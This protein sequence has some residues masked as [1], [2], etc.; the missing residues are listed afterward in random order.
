MA[1][2]AG[3]MLLGTSV[4]CLALTGCA[5][6]RFEFRGYS[7]LSSCPEIIDAELANGATFQ[8]G[9]ASEDVENPGYITELE[10]EIF[11]QRVRIDILCNPQGFIG[12]IHYISPV[13]DPRETGPIFRRFAAGLETLFGPPTEVTGEDSRSLRFLC[14]S[15][16]PLLVDE[17]RVAGGEEADEDEETIHEVYV[18]VM[19]RVAE[20]LD[21]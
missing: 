13:T 21:D 6:P 7:D 20:C 16:A 4:T 10:G 11:E 3:T 8:G 12:S 19:P 2:R 5:E 1:R 14:H 9:Y 18:A 17:W 15:P